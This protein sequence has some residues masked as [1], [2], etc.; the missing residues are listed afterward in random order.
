[1]PVILSTR[2][3]GR[4]YPEHPTIDKF[5]YVIANVKIDGKEYYLDATEKLL[6]AGLLPKR[7]L[8]W[9]GRK[10]YRFN[11][12]LIDIKPIG[13]DKTISMFF[14]DLNE[15]KI[16]GSVQKSYI[17]YA[18]FDKRKEIE[19]EGNSK[20]YEKKFIKDATKESISDYKLKNVEDIYKPITEEY[21][22]STSDNITF[23]GDM[24]Y[25]SPMLNEAISENPFKLEKREY[26][27]D[28]AYPISKKIIMQYTIP[29]GYEIVEYP[30]NVSYTLHEK[31][32]Q[33]QYSISVVGNK[34]QV[35][36]NFKI[37]KTLYMLDSYIALKNFYNLV[38]EKQKE[39]VVFRKIK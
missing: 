26:P 6:P 28:Y 39:Q 25:L 35:I 33:F 7:C 3:N 4:L 32:A 34:M 17:D 29:E 18:A 36:S 5:N 14:L 15:N 30:K 10:L 38:I 24:I 37:N 16:N 12:Q 19:K 21:A 1:M 2:D 23:A 22:L 11:G 13:K 31:A 20:D 27:V 9:K 8:N